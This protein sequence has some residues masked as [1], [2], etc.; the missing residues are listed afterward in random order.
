M[1]VPHQKDEQ[2]ADVVV[3]VGPFGRAVTRDLQLRHAPSYLS[4]L[5]WVCLPFPF[6]LPSR[7]VP[8]EWSPLVSVACRAHA[9][10]RRATHPR[11]VPVCMA[12]PAVPI[13]IAIVPCALVPV[14]F[15]PGLRVVPLT[16]APHALVAAL[17]EPSVRALPM[18]LAIAP[19]AIVPVPTGPGLRTVP[20]LLATSICA[21]VAVLV[22]SVSLP[23]PCVVLSWHTPL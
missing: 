8:S 7:H 16:V 3:P 15:G 6:F 19:R 10:C 13:L 2:R 14:S 20:T 9:Y 17:P 11:A 4:P 12:Q 21:L 5:A 1:N 22:V 23:C 18:L